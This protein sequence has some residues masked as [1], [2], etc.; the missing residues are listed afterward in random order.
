MVEGGAVLL[1]PCHSHVHFLPM[2]LK[3]SLCL[4][5]NLKEKG[6]IKLTAGVALQ[7]AEFK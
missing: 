4:S 3:H 6:K 5:V 2:L 1:A 7:K